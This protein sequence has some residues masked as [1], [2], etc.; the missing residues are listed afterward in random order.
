ML[1]ALI[2]LL[3]E[4]VI[5]IIIFIGFIIF[6]VVYWTFFHSETVTNPIDTGRPEKNE[7]ILNG[8]RVILTPHDPNKLWEYSNREDCEEKTIE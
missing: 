1:T 5:F 4:V 2:V 7:V 8:N 3:A 6:V